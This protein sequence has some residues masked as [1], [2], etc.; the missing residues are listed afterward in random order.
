[1][2]VALTS[3]PEASVSPDTVPTHS[4]MIVS[5]SHD[6]FLSRFQADWCQLSLTAIASYLPPPSEGTLLIKTMTSPLQFG[7]R[8]RR[9]Q[10]FLIIT[11]F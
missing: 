7:F 10:Y 9:M 5:C 3:S 4:F 1:M 2:P 8:S 6:L 11:S